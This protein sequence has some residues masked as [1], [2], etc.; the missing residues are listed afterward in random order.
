MFYLFSVKKIVNKDPLGAFF[1]YDGMV[2]KKE[3]KT[4]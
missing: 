2:K 3:I 4:Q 1:C